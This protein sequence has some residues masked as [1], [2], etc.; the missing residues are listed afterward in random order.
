[1]DAKKLATFVERADVHQRILGD[2]S[3]PYSLG[4]ARLPDHPS[5]LIL[6]V[7]V[8]AED[9]NYFPRTIALDGELVQIVVEGGFQVP[10]PL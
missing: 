6:R 5:E 9:L 4:I 10:T 8:Q 1:M 7:R 2:Y 3:G